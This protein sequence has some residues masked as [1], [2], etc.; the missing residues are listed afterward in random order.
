MIRVA[1]KGLGL[2]LTTMVSVK[3]K[4]IL[5]RDA[6]AIITSMARNYDLPIWIED[7]D[8]KILL[9]DKQ[10]DEQQ[11]HR[12]T[13]N[14]DLLGWVYGSQKAASIADLVSYLAKREDETRALSRE[15]LAKY[16]EINLLYTISA[17][18]ATCLEPGSIAELVLS[19]AG[20]F[21]T[22]T[23]ASL[24]LFNEKTGFLEII[25]AQG[26]NFPEKFECKPGQ[27]IAGNVFSTG[28]G[29]IFCDVQESPW[30]VELQ[31]KI[32]SLICIPLTVEDRTT[33]VINISSEHQ[34]AYSAE[35]FKFAAALASLAAVSIE[36]ARLHAKQS[37]RKKIEHELELARNIQ[38]SLLPDD[39]PKVKGLDIA[40]IALPAK[41][42]GGDFYDFIPLSENRLGLVVAD[43]SGKG[44]PAAL[45]MALSRA[46]M[47]ITALRQE[48]SI[49]AVI[50]KTN[51]LI[52]EF[53]SSGYF[54][55][56]FYA[57][58]DSNRNTLQYVRAGHNPPL[59]YRPGNDEIL[60][61]KGAGMVL[62]VVDEIELEA[63]QIDLIPGDTLLLF[64]D[65]AT[66]AINP[67]NEEFGVDRLSELIRTNHHLE[68]DKIIDVIKKEINEFAGGE[69][70]FDDLTLLVL[71]V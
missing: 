11:K 47:R 23:S 60:F 9:G 68:A 51:Q 58:V 10:D 31:N 70:Q 21:I 15:T 5:K 1:G 54:V 57:I 16:K 56:L 4:K 26:Q 67:I 2:F 59:L 63:K 45:F 52:Q 19:E 49:A 42:I 12:I 38:Q 7:T 64:T 29:D 32:T 34:V 44:V 61:L 3:L 62:G 14:D 37:E 17:K 48:L 53:A 18:M 24:M 13:L 6:A 20:K 30:F 46:L 50:G 28:R 71:K 65:G 33:G 66:E 40:A 25:A 41:Q 8:G 27:G 35:D 55:T 39:A 69:P 36:N 43:V 22:A